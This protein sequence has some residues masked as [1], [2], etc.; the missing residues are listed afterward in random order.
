M[1]AAVDDRDSNLRAPQRPR[2]VEAAET[3][4]DDHDMGKGHEEYFMVTTPVVQVATEG[5]E[6]TE[7]G[8]DGGDGGNGFNT[9]KRRRTETNGED[10]NRSADRI[11]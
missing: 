5:K 3:A 9:K 8:K 6:R 7:G 11:A 4:A 10:N 2:C 1:V